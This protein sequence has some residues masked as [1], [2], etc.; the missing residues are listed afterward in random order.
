[1]CSAISPLERPAHSRRSTV[2]SRSV[3]GSANTGRGAARRAPLLGVVAAADRFTDLVEVLQEEERD[4]GE[5]F[6]AHTVVLVAERDELLPEQH[7]AH[8][9]GLHDTAQRHADAALVGADPR[10]LLQRLGRRRTTVAQR[11]VPDPR[12]EQAVLVDLGRIMAV[13]PVAI[14]RNAVPHLIEDL[15]GGGLGVGMERREQ[16]L[17]LARGGDRTRP[18]DARCKPAGE[19]G[20]CA[21]DAE[22]R[23]CR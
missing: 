10:Q 23:L 9:E 8:P 18:G 14:L 19:R 15:L 5:Q 12:A 4:L 2:R 6:V 20:R 21:L 13:G 16:A 7:R 22:A 1:M 3:S 11:L 17:Q